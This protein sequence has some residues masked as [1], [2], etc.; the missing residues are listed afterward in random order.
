[1]SRFRGETI[2]LL[3]AVVTLASA[4]LSWVP[5]IQQLAAGVGQET[6]GKFYGVCVFGTLALAGLSATLRRRLP[7]YGGMPP[8]RDFVYLVAPA[9]IGSSYAVALGWGATVLLTVVPGTLLQAMC[10]LD[11]IVL[12]WCLRIAGS[13]FFDYQRTCSA[14]RRTPY[15]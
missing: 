5:S 6:P 3:L 11:V 10:V 1:M 4:L 14:E 13:A 15:C 8:F 12:L 9:V 2:V 7:I